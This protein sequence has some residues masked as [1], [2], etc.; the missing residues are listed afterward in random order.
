M[1]SKLLLRLTQLAS[2]LRP[3]L[4]LSVEGVGQKDS[5]LG[6]IEPDGH[7]RGAYT[8][9]PKQAVVGAEKGTKRVIE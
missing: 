4:A 3:L 6:Q 2:S 8:V 1:S 5:A 9:R 7:G